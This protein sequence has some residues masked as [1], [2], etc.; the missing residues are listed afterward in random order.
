MLEEIKAI[1]PTLARYIMAG[2]LGWNFFENVM[3]HGEPEPESRYNGWTALFALWFTVAL[4]K[5]GGFW[6]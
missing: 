4:L 1:L 2:M 6:G 5:M 3:H